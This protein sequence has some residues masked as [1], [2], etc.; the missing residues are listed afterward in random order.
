MFWWVS[1][2]VDPHLSGHMFGNQSPFLNSKV[3]HLS[4]NS[5]ILTVSLGTELSG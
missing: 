3:P 4:G 2:T 1:C 5:V